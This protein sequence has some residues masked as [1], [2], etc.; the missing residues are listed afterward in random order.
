MERTQ[1][2]IIQNSNMSC[3]WRPAG[4]W[5]SGGAGGGGENDFVGGDF[6]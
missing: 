6:L 3:Y 5:E 4:E 1:L 2:T